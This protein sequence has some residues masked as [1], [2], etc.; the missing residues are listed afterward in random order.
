MYQI[1]SKDGTASEPLDVNSL[2]T[3]ALENKLDSQQP[4]LDSVTGQ[5]L[6]AGEMLIGQVTFPISAYYDSATAIAPLQVTPRPDS[7]LL[8]L[9]FLAL[10]IDY[11][12]ALPIIVLSFIPF[13]GIIFAPLTTLYFISRDSFFGGRSLGK[14]AM[15]LKVVRLDGKPVVWGTSVQRNISFFSHL[16]AAIPFIGSIYGP[17]LIGLVGIVEI[18]LVLATQLRIG[19][20]I[21]QS[22]VVRN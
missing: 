1:I 8:G 15:G 18:V 10:M 17:G 22:V 5:T 14:K 2:Q 21:A 9:R 3:L 7:S 6:P 13:V 20:N 19:D 4:L 11:L 12:C 16:I